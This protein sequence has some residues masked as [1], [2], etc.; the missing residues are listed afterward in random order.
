MHLNEFEVFFQN[1]NV[2]VTGGAGF[3]GSNLVKLLVSLDANVTSLD[4]Y[5]SGLVA[6]HHDGCTY[7]TGSA[8]NIFDFFDPNFFDLI[9]HFGEYSRVEPSIKFSGEALDNIYSPMAKVLEFWRKSKAKLIYSGSSTKFSE[10]GTGRNLSPYTFAK[11]SN[12]D[13]VVNY[14]NWFGLPYTLVYFY[15]VY[16]KNEIRT[17]DYATL[18]GRYKHLVSTGHSRLPVTLP[19]TQ[20][21]NFTHID[22][23]IRGIIISTINGSGDLFGIGADDAYSVLEVCR[24]FGCEP[25]YL[26]LN[27]ANRMKGRVLNEKVKQLGWSQ[28]RSLPNDID[29]FLNN[30]NVS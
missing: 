3:I 30:L 7:V 19:G 23:V 27:V 16:G 13:L 26:P 22:D 5:L 1:K 6:N 4:N 8:A 12:S 29:F 17:G 10:D 15:N 20:V 2:L 21:R 28:L 9:F 18:I 11:A 25:E 24:M 14:A